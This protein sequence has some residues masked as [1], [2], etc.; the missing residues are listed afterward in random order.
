M[1]KC[2]TCK[3]EISPARLAARPFAQTCTSCK[4][5]CDEPKHTVMS[6]AVR[7]ALVESSLCD[8]QE[9]AKQ[10]REIQGGD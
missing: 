7:G 2:K 3:G 4:S 9:M 8:E 1:R 6:R 5:L 10:A